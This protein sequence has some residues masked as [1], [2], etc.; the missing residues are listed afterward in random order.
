VGEVARAAGLSG[1]GE[2]AVEG[3]VVPEEQRPELRALLSADGSEVL[4]LARDDGLAWGL[5]VRDGWAGSGWRRV[6]VGPER[7]ASMLAWRMPVEG[8][9]GARLLRW[10]LP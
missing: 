4:V 8:V 3:F 7:G 6:E 9:E 2:E 1:E 10:V 5:E